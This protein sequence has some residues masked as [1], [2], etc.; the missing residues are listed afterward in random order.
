MNSSVSPKDEISFLL[1]CPHISNVVYQALLLRPYEGNEK[2]ASKRGQN[3]LAKTARKLAVLKR[4]FRV[5]IYF[6]ECKRG[7]M[8]AYREAIPGGLGAEESQHNLHAHL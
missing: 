1:V 8:M 5:G 4:Y 2:V 3:N 7:D 6:R